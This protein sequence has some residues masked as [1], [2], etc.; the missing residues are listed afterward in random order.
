MI[1]REII[2]LNLLGSL[3]ISIKWSA[4]KKDNFANINSIFKLQTV[5]Q[6]A[7]KMI[8]L[9]CFTHMLNSQL[10]LLTYGTIFLFLSGLL[11]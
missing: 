4:K 7:F 9:Y 10:L 6:T 3:W 2:L 5:V 8:S 1:H 11:Y